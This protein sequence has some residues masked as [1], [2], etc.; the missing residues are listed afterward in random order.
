M[1]FKERCLFLS[2]GIR[3]L[4]GTFTAKYHFSHFQL[5]PEDCLYMIGPSLTSVQHC[6]AAADVIVLQHEAE[7]VS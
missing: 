1:N 7:D 6:K 3:L 2:F 5:M 4:L